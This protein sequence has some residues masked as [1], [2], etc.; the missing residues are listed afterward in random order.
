[1]R[2]IIHD[3]IA[4]AAGDVRDDVVADERAGYCLLAVTAAGTVA[5]PDAVGRLVAVTLTGC[6][7]HR[8]H[9]PLVAIRSSRRSRRRWS[10]KLVGMESRR[11]VHQV[12]GRPVPAT[13][14][15]TRYMPG[16]DRG[17][18]VAD[19]RPRW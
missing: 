10:I 9:R 8:G 15:S 4:G 11:T 2:D 17:R 6:A 3:L 12:L 5:S 7:G 13:R 14:A 1:V 16:R 19:R 18:R